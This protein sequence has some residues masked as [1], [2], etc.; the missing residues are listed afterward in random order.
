MPGQYLHKIKKSHTFERYYKL[1][2]H[3]QDF[4]GALG[5]QVVDSSLHDVVIRVTALGEAVEEHGQVVM[6]V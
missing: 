1:W 5:D 3:R 6:K 4:V 2:H